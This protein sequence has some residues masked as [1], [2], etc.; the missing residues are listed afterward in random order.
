MRKNHLSIIFILLSAIIISSSVFA[1]V[2]MPRYGINEQTKEC[3]EFFMGDE[4]VS[5]VMPNAWEIIEESQCPQD[6]KEV[7]TD[8]I[9]T[10]RKDSFCCT[11]QHSGAGGDCEDVVVNSLEKKCAFVEDIN[12]CEKLLPNWQKAEEVEFWGNVC[13]SLEFEWM[14]E[15]INCTKKIIDVNTKG[16]LTDISKDNQSISNQ[17]LYLLVSAGLMA[18][19]I[20]GWFFLRKK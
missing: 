18:L 8:S 4:C 11:V 5:C 20:L 14:E 6:Y 10:P 13:P 9:C 15:Q 12:K 1:S 19:I 16:N 7:Q 2:A 3:S 17:N